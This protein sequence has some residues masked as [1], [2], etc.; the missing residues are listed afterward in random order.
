MKM[1]SLFA[2]VVVLVVVASAIGA[3]GIK[4]DPYR[5]SEIPANTQQS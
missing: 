3:C 1:R 2:R 4:G 5:P